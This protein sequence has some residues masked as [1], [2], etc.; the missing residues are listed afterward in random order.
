M[1][2]GVLWQPT[3]GGTIPF[4]HLSTLD[5]YAMEV[6]T[7]AVA[8][9]RPLPAAQWLRSRFCMVCLL[10]GLG[11][12]FQPCGPARAAEALER[13]AGEG[14]GADR[15]QGEAQRGWEL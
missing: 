15:L 8:F 5:Q 7:I 11:L 2:A 12:L 3:F 9:F 10:A 13:T 14:R 1:P 6:E 4:I